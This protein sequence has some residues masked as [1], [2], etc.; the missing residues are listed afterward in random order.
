MQGDIPTGHCS[1]EFLFQIF[2]FR[3]VTVPNGH[4][5][6][7]VLFQDIVIPKDHFNTSK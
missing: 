3:T 4:Y 5:S 6:K 7:R 2:I 1:E